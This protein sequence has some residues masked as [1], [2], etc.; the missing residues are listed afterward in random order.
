MSYIFQTFWTYVKVVLL[1]EDALIMQKY[2]SDLQCSMKNG[3]KGQCS[4]NFVSKK[5]KK[6]NSNCSSSKT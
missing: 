4:L 3:Q 1:L 5:R 6:K 2:L